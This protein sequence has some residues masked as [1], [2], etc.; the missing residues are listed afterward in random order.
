[1]R[2][3]FSILVGLSVL[4]VIVSG[5]SAQTSSEDAVAKLKA[6]QQQREAERAKTVEISYGELQDLK[7]EIQSLKRELA[8]YKVKSAGAM[9][10]ANKTPAVKRRPTKMELG[11]TREDLLWF[12]NNHP[13]DYKII[14]AHADTGK[15]VR[16]EETVTQRETQGDSQVAHNGGTPQ[17]ESKD[18]A[19]AVKE[20]V[21]HRTL[22]AK[23]ETI[24]LGI[25]GQRE[26]VTGTK[27]DALG[28]RQTLTGTELVQKGKITI[29]LTDDVV[30]Q[31]DGAGL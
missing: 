12:I 15:T 2:A 27:R 6:R 31:I 17:T 25:L 4:L 28:H 9:V 16:K 20:T 13:R 10:S 22:N 19:S 3:V 30:S 5:S 23:H 14:G 29:Q 11:M 7:E 24:V 1:M 8:E 26:V 18:G 21:E